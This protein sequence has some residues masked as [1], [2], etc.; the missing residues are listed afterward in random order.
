[1]TYALPDDS[2]LTSKEAAKASIDWVKKQFENHQTEVESWLARV[3]VK[4]QIPVSIGEY[5]AGKSVVLR[6]SDYHDKD[7]GDWVYSSETC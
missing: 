1:M 4:H 3:A 6:K 2:T 5:G 7:V